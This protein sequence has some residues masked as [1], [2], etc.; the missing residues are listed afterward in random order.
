MPVV[1]PA[2]ARAA[3]LAGLLA[4]PLVCVVAS[5]P[6]PAV[7]DVA[8]AI[9]R[10]GPILT[11]RGDAPEYVES[12]AVKDGRIL[13]V[14]T[15]ADAGGRPPGIVRVELFGRYGCCCDILDTKA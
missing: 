10:G 12:L 5:A 11:M 9:Y 1:R 3:L 4:A 8:D 13:F 2:A 7:A 6:S 15:A 14:G